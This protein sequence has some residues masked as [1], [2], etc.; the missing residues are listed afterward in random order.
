MGW[1]LLA[2]WVPQCR[3]TARIDLPRAEW[4]GLW[5]FLR[6]R[7]QQAA[8]LRPKIQSPTKISTELD[9]L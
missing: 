2:A 5:R 3:G 7:G 6:W 8:L 4:L 9:G 1:L